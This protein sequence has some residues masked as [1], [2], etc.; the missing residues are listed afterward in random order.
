MGVKQE[1]LEA[2]KNGLNHETF[3][4]LVNAIASVPNFVHDYYWAI[5]SGQV[6]ARYFVEAERHPPLNMEVFASVMNDL[7]ASPSMTAPSTFQGP[8]DVLFGDVDP[9]TDAAQ[10]ALDWKRIFPQA[11]SR[12]IPHCGH[13]ML[14]EANP[15]D[16]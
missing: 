7:L 16:W 14:F 9:L 1:L 5:G 2:A 13:F 6:R 12:T 11:N 4:P 10:D 3:W 8:V 15:V